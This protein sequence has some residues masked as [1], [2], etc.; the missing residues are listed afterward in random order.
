MEEETIMRQRI[1]QLFL[2]CDRSSS[3]LLPEEPSDFTLYFEY[4][5]HDYYVGD[6]LIN[7]TRAKRSAGLRSAFY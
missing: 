4:D 7:R 5:T 2:T 1:A 3:F 6:K